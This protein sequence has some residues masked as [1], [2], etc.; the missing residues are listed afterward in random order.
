MSDGDLRAII[1]YIQA[2]PAVENEV[3][4]RELSFVTRNTTGLFESSRQV[5]GF[6]PAI[7]KKYEDPYGRYLVDHVARC[8]SCHNTPSTLLVA[9]KYLLG[10]A[11]VK[12]EKGDKA[13]PAIDQ[14]DDGGIGRWSKEDIVAYLKTGYTPDN[15]LIDPAYCPTNFYA[16][17]S[18]EDLTLIAK[19]LKS[20][21]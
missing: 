21:K 17:A 7:D 10:G 3:R 5:A 2:L 6:I 19:Y 1:S 20:V 9:E 16:N 4:G 12:T 18:D 8:G 14:D 11:L 13:A 15:R